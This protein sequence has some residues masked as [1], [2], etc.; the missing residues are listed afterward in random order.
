MNQRIVRSVL[1]AALLVGIPTGGFRISPAIAQAAPQASVW[2]SFSSETGRFSVLMPGTP[3]QQ[4]DADLH[5][6]EVERP[7]DE[8]RYSVAYQDFPTAIPT[9]EADLQQAFNQLRRTIEQEDG[10]I[11][12]ESRLT[13]GG[14]P[15]IEF[16]IRFPKEGATGQARVFLVKQ[17]VYSLVVKTSNGKNLTKSME[18][19]FRSFQFREE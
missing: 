18:G 11:T 8:V 2:Q 17:R 9:T 5:L 4:T 14:Y 16:K 7:Q 10:T 3:Q 6:F 13:L 15:G 1:A 12:A 19:F